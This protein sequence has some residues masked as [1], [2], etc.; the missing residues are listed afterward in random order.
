MY[1]LA[2]VPA[3]EWS[4]RI[5]ALRLFPQV[6]EEAGGRAGE[7]AEPELHSALETLKTS[8]GRDVKPLEAYLD[9]HPESPWRLSLLT[10]LGLHYRQ[11]GFLSR[12]VKAWEEAWSLG[13]GMKDPRA[14]GWT[15]Q[16]GAELAEL[17]A[18]LG[19]TEQLKDLLKE[20]S[21]RPLRG[22]TA[23]RVAY[24]R[25]SLDRMQ[26][27]PER[28]YRCGPLSVASLAESLG[29]PE[30]KLL[31]ERGAPSGTSLAYNQALAARYGITL[32][33][34]KGKG[35][36]LP[37]LPSILHFRSG[38]FATVVSEANGRFLVKDPTFGDDAWFTREALLDEWSGYVLA[39]G[40]EA[41][42]GFTAVKGPEA[43]TVMGM[44]GAPLGDPNQ[45]R[46]CNTQVGGK[47]CSAEKGCHAMPVHTFHSLL[48]SL[49]IR[50]TPV[51]YAP[52]VGPSLFFRIS[53]SQRDVIQPQAF[54]Y[55]N[56]GSKWRFNY[57]AYV[58]DD[59]TVAIDGPTVSMIVKL[60]GQGGGLLPF[61]FDRAPG[62]QPPSRPET[63]PSKAQADDRSV[64]V[65][66]SL[67]SY[68]RY[69]PDGTQ[70]VYGHPDGA[71]LYPR[72]VFLTAVVDATGARSTITYDAQNRIV[73]VIDAQGR[74]T[75]LSYEN[76]DPLKVTKVTD[77]FGRS[78]KFEYDAAG[79]LFRVTDVAGLSTEFLYGPTTEA[80]S[81]PI[82][83]IHT[84]RTPYGSYRYFQ[85]SDADGRWVEAVDP[86]GG[87]ERSEFKRHPVLKAN[88]AQLMPPGF[89]SRYPGGSFY[90]NQRVMGLYPRD[91][92]RAQHTRWV[93][94]TDG[95]GS[96]DIPHSLKGAESADTYQ[97][98]F[99]YP[100]Q[101]DANTKGSLSLPSQVIRN[102]GDGFQ[103][104]RYEY[105]SQGRPT[106]VTDPLG[107][108][109][110]MAYDAN[111][112]DLLSVQQSA[113][114]RKETLA[115][116]TYNTQHLPL[117]ATDAAGQVTTFTYNAAGQLTSL[118]NPLR[119]TTT[120]T[121]NGLGQLEK[122]EGPGGRTS[123]FT[124]DAVG[125]VWT[126]TDPEGERVV[127]DYDALDRP[128]KVAYSDGTFEQLVYDRLDVA[129]RKDRTGRWT[130][131]AY[132][133]LRQLVEVKDA[134]G[135]VTRMDWCGCG[136]LDSLTDPMGR[137]TNWVRDL[138]NQVIAK[139]LPD[140][141]S[142]TFNYDLLGRL[143][144]R[145]D[146]KGQVTSYGYNADNSL[147]QIS[148][149]NSRRA[150]AGASVS[151]TYETDYNRL[152]SM[153][154]ATGTTRYAYHP[155][156][157]PPQLG[158]GRLA[159]ETS[160]MANSTISYGYDELGRVV[161][162]SINGASSSIS[163]DALGRPSQTTNA[164]GRFTFG[165]EGTTSRLS[166]LGL[167]NG[168]TTAFSYYDA[169]QQHRLKEI[170]HQTS[171]GAAVSKFGYTY[172]PFGQIKTWSQQA[173]A[174]PPKTHTFGYDAVGQLLEAKL[175]GPNGDLLKTFLYGYDQAGNR[176]S[177][178]VD[179]Q[180]TSGEYNDANQLMKQST[181]PDTAPMQVGGKAGAKA[182]RQ[183]ASGSRPTKAQPSNAKPKTNP[184]V[185]KA[186]AAT[187]QP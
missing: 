186:T 141:T 67:T 173:D 65:R 96:V 119:Q 7:G 181:A 59:P 99:T 86:L 162:R 77:P 187:S 2:P 62:A 75:A 54:N 6:I 95:E 165:F 97:T 17:R 105:N 154:D 125:R 171:G 117:T 158:A 113:N 55:S 45:N 42:S 21:G 180:F 185:P 120:L 8:Q 56:L 28:N 167:P 145:V 89:T 60:H 161:N 100:G 90:W 44:G 91:Y 153:T 79:Q 20:L 51:G 50:D 43:T 78:A 23:E 10:Q 118:S 39:P 34:L 3:D 108:E 169:T 9:G 29:R 127:I 33:A 103:I 52:A 149:S 106:K 82:D 5:K 110:W 61:V 146:A 159:T 22:S 64:L 41:P 72:R 63:G 128:T 24:A 27:T 38:H 126:V 1:A 37:P 25:E 12:A 58:V 124:Y 129:S 16:A 53:Y 84:M 87:R 160:P 170:Q 93:W 73:S 11:A 4:A 166:A 31:D 68:V 116:Y 47:G 157:D 40:K 101:A 30:P 177:S 15:D 32:L 49:F 134:L 112:M 137:V 179:G 132:N 172:D 164:L 57:Q 155:V 71:L 107:R 109:T 156:N 48:A 140:R 152:A 115:K 148:Y 130:T 150:K 66:S 76:A 168:M 88:D 35:P 123:S 18:R 144:R 102:T 13:R 111:Q 182:G 175:A 92:N 26:T 36:V 135:R 80:P 114:G 184:K 133:A 69:F 83:F 174:L 151:F 183:K 122:V 46:D 143:V 104:W 14:A 94:G 142:T 138:D 136:T 139:I 70:E 178:Q 147:A 85:G 81:N 176:T 98:W 74:A 121:Y 131:M 163:Y 19:R